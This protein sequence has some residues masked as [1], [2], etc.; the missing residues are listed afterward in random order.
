MID[1]QNVTFG[2]NRK[3][4]LFTDLSLT[5]PKGAV[6]G[7]LGK[8]GAGKSS[9]LKNMAG[10]LFPVSGKCLVNGREA[11]KREPEFLQDI[12]FIP[13]E[14]YVPSVPIRS[15]VKTYAPFYPA[16]NAV[17]FQNYLKEFGID[18]SQTLTELSYGQKKKVLIGFGLATNTSVLIMDEPTNGLDIPSKTQFRKIIA[19]AAT[20]DRIIIISTHQVRDLESLID[21]IIILDGSEILLYASIEQITEKLCFKTVSKVEEPESVLYSEST[22][23]GI[24]L[25]QENVEGEDSKVDLELLFNAALATKEKIRQLFADK[26]S[27]NLEK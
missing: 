7:L 27:A 1:I 22:V 9:L 6:Y 21:P 25:V 10:L 12:F 16:F 18:D 19:S 24:S 2:Y 17:Q 20:E 15:F 8:N 13:E 5:L 14:F 26:V 4:R 11:K 3:K 23:R